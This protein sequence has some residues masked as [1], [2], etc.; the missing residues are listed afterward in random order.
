MIRCTYFR[1]LVQAVSCCL[2]GSFLRSE[3]NVVIAIVDSI[4][5]IRSL[6]FGENP[7][8]IFYSS[9]RKRISFFIRFTNIVIFIL[10]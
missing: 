9:V 2:K 7:L 5:K 10:F 8:S 3:I 4:N 6:A 1:W